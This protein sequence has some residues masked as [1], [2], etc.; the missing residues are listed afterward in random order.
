MT[1]EV[2]VV[3][4]GVE[5]SILFLYEE[6]R[7]LGGFQWFDFPQVKVFIDEVIDSLSFSH[8]EGI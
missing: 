4:A 6:G 1:V 3:L 7:G 2:S 8:G 5:A